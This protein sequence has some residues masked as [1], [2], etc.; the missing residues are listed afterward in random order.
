[1]AKQSESITATKA[2]PNEAR[3][4][5]QSATMKPLALKSP[6]ALGA[7]SQ[8]ID[9]VRLACS[10][11]ALDQRELVATGKIWGEVLAA[12]G[13]PLEHWRKCLI[14]CLRTRNSSFAVNVSELC[15]AWRE[16]KRQHDSPKIE[17]APDWYAEIH[18]GAI[19]GN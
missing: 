12:E 17:M 10:L 5:L 1:M 13:I 7:L 4:D 2:Q 3:G 19:H 6:Q 14:H 9:E 16:I 11:P 15:A 18:K 8:L